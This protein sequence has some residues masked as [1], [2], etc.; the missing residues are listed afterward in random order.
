MASVPLPADLDDLDTA[1]SEQKPQSSS[2]LVL[3]LIIAGLALLLIP[4]YQI[5][6]TVSDDN[7]VLEAQIADLEATLASTPQP[8]SS[9]QAL[10][11]QLLQVQTQLKALEDIQP[12]LTA[13]HVDWL[14]VIGIISN[15]DPQ[16]IVL[17]G[18]TQSN[19]RV[20]LTGQAVDE[21]TVMAYTQMLKDSNQFKRVIVQSIALKNASPLTSAEVKAKLA[22]FIISFELPTNP[23]KG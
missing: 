22:D 7:A 1:T 18:L 6:A 16:D 21:S 9:D 3:W 12:T 19:N 20:I 11:A 8:K 4:L 13:N 2:R 23:V 5:S 15:C 14:T 10:K 17:T